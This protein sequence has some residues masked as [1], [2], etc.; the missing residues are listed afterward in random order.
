MLG[1]KEVETKDLKTG[2]AWAIGAALGAVFVYT[3]KSKLDELEVYKSA[4]A[5]ANSQRPLCKDDRSI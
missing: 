1:M 4:E 5:R 3:I 2:A